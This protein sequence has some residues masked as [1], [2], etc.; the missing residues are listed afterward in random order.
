M[1]KTSQRL[2]HPWHFSQAV[3][4]HRGL[5]VEE[6]E[7]G[8]RGAAGE[9]RARL[10]GEAQQRDALPLITPV[11]SACP[12]TRVLPEPVARAS[13]RA[14]RRGRG[15]HEPELRLEGAKGRA[16]RAGSRVTGAR[17]PSD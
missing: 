14:H 11:A 6:V 5:H 16:P 17:S 10:R 12:C 2:L 1:A 15:S 4:S 8:K 3:R 13:A 9:P 7:S